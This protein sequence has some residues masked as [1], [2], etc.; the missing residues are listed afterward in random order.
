MRTEVGGRGERRD[1]MACVSGDGRV[2]ASGCWGVIEVEGW[3]YYAP[4][5]T[6]EG[7]GFVR[8]LRG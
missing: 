1:L 5:F 2:S 8:K 7:L 6:D 4:C 3:W